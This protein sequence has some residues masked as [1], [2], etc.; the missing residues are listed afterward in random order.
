MLEKDKMKDSVESVDPREDQQER[1]HRSGPMA[2]LR[3]RF[4]RVGLAEALCTYVMMVFG[5][6]S[7]AQVVTGHGAF[8]QYLSIN[9]G[10]G[11]GVTMGVHVGGSVSGAHMNAAVSLAMCM[12]GRLAWK[13]L[14]VYVFAQFLGSF[15]AAA[16]IY[17]VFNGK[18]RCSHSLLYCCWIN[19]SWIELLPSTLSIPDAIFDFGDGNLTTTGAKATA[20]IFATYPAPYLSLQSGFI[21]QVLGTAMLLLCLTA[22]SD[23][24]NKPAARGSES[25]MVGLLVMLIGVSL[26]SNS[27][28]PINPTRDLAPRLFTAVAGWGN[29]VFRAGNGWWWV[30]VVAPLLGGV[31][32]AGL[33]K[34]L[35]E[36]HHPAIVCGQN[37][38]GEQE[39]MDPLEKQ[40]HADVCV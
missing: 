21:D 23:Q 29:E 9:I 13:M 33:Y 26:G 12:F 37:S 38:H 18:D 35:V 19:C 39:E 24:R 22:L 25:L 2:C 40:S 17:T 1:G 6:G 31:M 27:G 15:L 11:L 28:Y 5:L 3:S 8:G 30:P 16:T 34:A 10:F 7:V 20:G 32:G 36:L 4:I 14:P